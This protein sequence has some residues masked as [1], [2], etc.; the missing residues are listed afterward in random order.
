[1]HF[2]TSFTFLLALLFLPALPATARAGELNPLKP[3][4]TSTQEYNLGALD[5]IVVSLSDKDGRMKKTYTVGQDGRVDIGGDSISVAGQS[6]TWVRSRVARNFPKDAEIIIEEFR[7]SKITVLGEVYHQILAEMPEG[8]MRLTDAI[9]TANGFTA[10]AN[11][12]RVRLIRQNADRISV[13]EINMQDIL[14]GK[15]VDQNILLE[16]GDVITVPRN[17]L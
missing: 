5:R 6:S 12:K 13:Y 16:P 8:P 2:K 10:L 3:V 15:N 14:N 7:P 9:A 4:E 1:M 11:R 17:F